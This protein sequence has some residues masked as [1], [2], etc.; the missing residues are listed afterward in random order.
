MWLSH[1]AQE[2]AKDA[3]FHIR[4]WAL[5]SQTSPLALDYGKQGGVE[6]HG[7][8]SL[9]AFPFAHRAS[10]L[11]LGRGRGVLDWYTFCAAAAKA[12]R[13][14]AP[15]AAGQR[16][17][18]TVGSVAEALV[19]Y[20]LRKKSPDPPAYVCSVRGRASIDTAPHY[21]LLGRKLLAW[22]RS[23][24]RAADL[25]LCNGRETVEYVE[26]AGFHAELQP[27]GVDFQFFARGGEDADSEDVDDIMGDR[28]LRYVL[29]TCTV[30]D[31]REIRGVAWRLRAAAVLRRIWGDGFRLI[32]I[33]A[34]DGR[35]YANL[36]RQL[37]IGHLT[38]FCGQ[39][40]NVAA[41]LKRAD[42]VTC[43][44][45]QGGG[46][47]HAALEAMA[48][49]TPITAVDSDTYRQLLT[50]RK[51]AMLVPPNDD[52]ALAKALSE[53][54]S[55]HELGRELGRRAQDVAQQYDW[56]QV[57]KQ[58]RQHIMLALQRRYYARPQP[59]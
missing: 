38:R 16:V 15:S 53:L 57:A 49:G 55:N 39:R 48:S 37:G 20:W 5:K 27:N 8:P 51:T 42:V 46:M 36:V 2:L 28:S 24:L 13:A 43:L 50:H 47:S 6:L 32:F 14:A 56:P 7:L 59:E 31:T 25:I 3:G 1:V 44:V 34:G 11:V 9:S 52:E 45:T 18:V 23:A 10:R 41:F 29:S 21:G 30:G 58:L 26:S 4:I 19:G 22:E 54:L 35:R 33:G 17:V 12:L 40:K